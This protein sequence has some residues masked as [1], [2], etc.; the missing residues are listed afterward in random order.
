MLPG[1]R[2]LCAAWFVPGVTADD[3]REDQRNENHGSQRE[4]ICP[5]NSSHGP[6]TFAT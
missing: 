6:M 2:G 1:T 3:R 4:A 5:D